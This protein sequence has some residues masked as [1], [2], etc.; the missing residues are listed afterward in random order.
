[1]SSKTSAEIRQWMKMLFLKGP[2]ICENG[3]GIMIP[4]T[5]PGELPAGVD[6]NGSEWRIDLGLTVEKVR[7]LLKEAADE[8]GIHY[9]GFGEMTDDE[10]AGYTGLSG[11]EIALSRQREY[12]EPFV[13]ESG[14][15]IG[16]FRE[17][18]ALK[19]LVITRGGRFHHAMGGCDKGKAVKVLADF[20]RKKYRDAQTVAVGDSLNDLPMFR[21]VDRA[22]LVKGH[23]GSHDS[24][25]PDSAASLVPGEGP[26]GFRAVIEEIM[27]VG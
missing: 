14:E 10:I 19:G 27:T 15:D 2:F 7:S 26:K 5:V 17:K 3:C 4:K 23:G 8:A 18:A 16:V 11:G 24:A 6:D 22:Y 12:D 21:A 25:I 1:V 13:I 9:K 20:Y